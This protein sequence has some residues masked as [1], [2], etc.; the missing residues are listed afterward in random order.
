MAIS[1]TGSI[2]QPGALLV[3]YSFGLGVPFLLTAVL[4]DNAQVVLKRLKRYM[5]AIK[6]FS[7]LLMIIIG[8]LIF[9]GE[10]QRIS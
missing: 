3:A 9:T 2:W 5:N 7:G 4:L 6:V 1:T 10:M 8:V